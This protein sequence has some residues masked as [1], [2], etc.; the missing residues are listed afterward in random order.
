MMPPPAMY[1]KLFCGIDLCSSAVTS[2]VVLYNRCYML[3]GQLHSTVTLLRMRS[4]ENRALLVCEN[5]IR[6]SQDFYET[7]LVWKFPSRDIGE[8]CASRCSQIMTQLYPINCNFTGSRCNIIAKVNAV[9]HGR[10][11]PYTRTTAYGT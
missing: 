8:K 4:I 2:Q 11:R 1:S 7:I 6:F 3:H 10:C 9:P 5:I